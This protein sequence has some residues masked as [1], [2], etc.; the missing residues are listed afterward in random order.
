MYLSG[1]YMFSWANF[2]YTNPVWLWSTVFI[3]MV[4]AVVY[5]IL[6][7]T[8]KFIKPSHELVADNVISVG[9]LQVIATAYA[10]LLAFIA[11]S[12]LSV[13]QDANRIA[14]TEASYISD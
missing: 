7:I 11:F 9:L 6:F 2:F 12:E 10:V 1:E 14:A 13:F 3:L 8:H 4:L 5:S